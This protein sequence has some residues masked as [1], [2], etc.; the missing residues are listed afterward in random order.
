[1]FLGATLRGVR[2]NHA[3]RQT[4]TKPKRLHKTG[5]WSTLFEYLTLNM[6]GDNP[7]QTSLPRCWWSLESLGACWSHPWSA[8]ELLGV[9]PPNSSRSLNVISDCGVLKDQKSREDFKILL[10]KAHSD[11][12]ILKSRSL[13]ETLTELRSRLDSL[14]THPKY[15][16]SS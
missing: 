13:L 15:F 8:L 6:E 12:R 16:G 1:M 9:F 4:E 2:W 3:F 14:S 10:Q 5:C 11:K 7:S